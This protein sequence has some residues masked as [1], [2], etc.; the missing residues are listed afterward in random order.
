M[1]LTL[2]ICFLVVVC[3]AFVR[4]ILSFEWSKRINGISFKDSLKLTD[5]PVI[6]LDNNGEKFNFLLDTGSNI[7]HFN[8]KAVNLLKDFESIDKEGQSIVTAT[9]TSEA[10]C[11]LRIP[12]GYKNQMFFE[13]FMLLNLKEA[14]DT[15]QKENGIQ[16]HGILGNSFFI[17]YGYVLD[18]DSNTIYIK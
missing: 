7:S 5:L 12:L 6:T 2:I 9:G 17:K 4:D 15:I 8:S 18:F 1:V 10:D 14:F 11:W 13:D 3:L 16:I